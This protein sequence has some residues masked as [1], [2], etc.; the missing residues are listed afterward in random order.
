MTRV[1]KAG[2]LGGITVFIWSCI[3]WM[4]LPWH[5]TTLHN[6]KDEKS[7]AQQIQA[8]SPSSGMYVLPQMDNKG[9]LVNKD[10]MQG[11]MVFAAVRLGPVPTT[12]YLQMAIGVLTQIIAAFFVAWLLFR[13]QGLNYFSRVIFVVIVAFAAGIMTDVCYWNWFGFDMQ[14]TLVEIA[15]LI[16]GWFFGGLI[17]AAFGRKNQ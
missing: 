14:Y 15:D 6:F 11:P 2:I 10:L 7:V 13:T 17:I 9:Q 4:V 5:M 3:S 8:N 1:I 12:M 16:V